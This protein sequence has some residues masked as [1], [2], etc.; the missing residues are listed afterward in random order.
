MEDRCLSRKKPKLQF[1][2]TSLKKSRA[3]LTSD[4]QRQNDYMA[5]NMDHKSNITLYTVEYHYVWRIDAIKKAIRLAK[6]PC[7]AH[8]HPSQISVVTDH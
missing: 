4:I 7:S 1:S 8:K 5:V 6:C 2:M 3:L